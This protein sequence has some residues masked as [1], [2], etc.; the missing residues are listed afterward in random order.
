MWIIL[1]AHLFQRLYLVEE[2]DAHQF[3]SVSIGFSVS[4]SKHTDDY[5]GM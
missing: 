5:C 1:E 4:V 2:I 3:V